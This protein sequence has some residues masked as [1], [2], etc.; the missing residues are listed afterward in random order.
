MN[1]EIYKLTPER[2]N[3][4][5]YFFENVAHSDNKEWD[6]C[7]CTN[8]CAANNNRITVKK[9]FADP[10]VRK[11]YAIDYVNNGL[12]Q[13][14]LAY[15][16]GNVIGWCNANDRNNCMHCYGW[17]HHISDKIIEKKSKEK[18]KSVFCFTVAPDFRGKGVATALLE[19]VI[20]D[21]RSDGY[22]YLESYPN[23]EKTDMY[24]NYVGPLALYKKLGFELYT[25][26]KQRLVLRKKLYD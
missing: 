23:K 17:K 21:A 13:G 24:Y 15:S 4:Y 8:Y 2:L 16:D 26:T 19:R 25:E 14:Y 5:L 20:E 9:N 3:D 10:D 7:Y 12:I 11:S 22:E 18:I 6:R 1:L